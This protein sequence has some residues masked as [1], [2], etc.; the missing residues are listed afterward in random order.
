MKIE[1]ILDSLIYDRT[2][3]D[4]DY[5]LSLRNSGVYTDENLRGAYNIS[6]RNRVGRVI[7]YLISELNLVRLHAKDDWVETDITKISDNDNIIVCLN[8]LR[9]VLEFEAV[10]EIPEDLD[11]LTYQKV[12]AVERVLYELCCAYFWIC[13]ASIFAGDG[14]A[15]DFDA[16]NRQIFDV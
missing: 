10:T 12:N 3:G 13:D 16:V 1:N 4:V 2:Q 6:D 15:S 5:A 14:Y 11:N 8:R 9:Q 7:N